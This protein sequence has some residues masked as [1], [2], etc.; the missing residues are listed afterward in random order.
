MQ[1]NPIKPLYSLEQKKSRA[2]IPKI[3]IIIVLCI[4]LYLGLLLNISLLLL[5]SRTELIIKI[6]AL[7][8]LSLIFLFSLIQGIIKANHK[9]EFYH[10][11]L[12]IN[13]KKIP[14]NTIISS[15]RKRDLADKIF[16]THSLSLGTGH[17]LRN[18]P[19][20][21]DL[22]TYLSK[23]IAYSKQTKHPS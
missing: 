14:Y 6:S 3:S 16:S 23:L 22:Q 10:S 4:I 1:I 18:I 2:L 9:Y 19:A 17:F 8:I 20:D 5:S 7:V 21:V 15:Q 13:D 11:Y 12:S